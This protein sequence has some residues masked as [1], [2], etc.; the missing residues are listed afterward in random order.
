MSANLRPLWPS[1]FLCVLLALL[2]G[3]SALRLGYNQEDTFVYLWVDRYVGDWRKTPARLV[4]RALARVPLTAG[5]RHQASH[6]ARPASA[7]D[8][9]C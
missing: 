9:S 4:D 5:D 3:C 1:A 7:D 8:A 6:A 2:A